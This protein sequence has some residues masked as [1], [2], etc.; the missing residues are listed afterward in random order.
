MKYNPLP[1]RYWQQSSTGKW[2][3]IPRSNSD[4][5]EKRLESSPRQKREAIAEDVELADLETKS[6]I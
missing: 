6:R 2:Y 1:T 3:S 5:T 4:A